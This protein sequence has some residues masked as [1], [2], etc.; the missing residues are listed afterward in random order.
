MHYGFQHH[1]KLRRQK[2]TNGSALKFIFDR[3]AYAAG[4]MIA[5]MTAPQI[6]QIY[7]THN[8]QGVSIFTWLMYG[9]GSC[10]WIG[11]GLVHHEKPIVFTNIVSASLQ[12]VVAIGAILYS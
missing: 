2:R 7:S 12:L 9:L 1:L 11:Y 3:V 4:V 5:I 6:W 10:F 8:A